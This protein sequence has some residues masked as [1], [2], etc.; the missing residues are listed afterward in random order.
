MRGGDPKAAMRKA[1]SVFGFTRQDLPLDL[2][3][4][5]SR[6]QKKINE[7]NAT[8]T[9]VNRDRDQFNAFIQEMNQC[10]AILNEHFDW[11][12]NNPS[13]FRYTGSPSAPKASSPKPVKTKPAS[14]D[15]AQVYEFFSTINQWIKKFGSFLQQ[16]GSY[17]IQLY[18]FGK[19]LYETGQRF[20]AIY[21]Q[22][23]AAIVGGFV[24]TILC[25]FLLSSRSCTSEKPNRHARQSSSYESNRIDSPREPDRRIRT[26]KG[27]LIVYAHFSKEQNPTPWS[28][29]T[30]YKNGVV[31]R[32]IIKTT[33]PM[34]DPIRVSP[35]EYSLI[36]DMNPH[37]FRVPEVTVQENR[38]SVVRV[39]DLN[40]TITFERISP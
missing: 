27:E 8:F 37:P 9:N 28:V 14:W 2:S 15:P 18:E 5:T 12:N 34:V 23:S 39:K 20:W 38:R 31:N 17:A 13:I 19:R 33:A 4:I 6:F 16:M 29:V 22:I 10:R 26:G 30:I 32:K 24:M 1:L 21:P 36:F 3:A 25:S 35:G 40:F 7:A 11:I